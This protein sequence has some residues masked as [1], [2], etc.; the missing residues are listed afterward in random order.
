MVAT[1]TGMP[2]PHRRVR[3]SLVVTGATVLIAAALLITPA[4]WFGRMGY[5]LFGGLLGTA[6]A[7][8]VL[9]IF[10]A[11]SKNGTQPIGVT[12]LLVGLNIVVTLVAWVV[13]F[14]VRMGVA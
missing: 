1:A 2:R 7:A 10:A 8:I 4:A 5:P 13:L 9:A 3:L 6:C 11:L 14:G 12:V